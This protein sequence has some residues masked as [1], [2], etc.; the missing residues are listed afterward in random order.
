MGLVVLGEDHASLVAAVEPLADLVVQRL[1]LGDLAEQLGVAKQFAAQNYSI[2][3]LFLQVAIMPETWRVR[4]SKAVTPT[5]V[6]M[7]G[8]RSTASR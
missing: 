4:A 3:A 1:L 6:S 5:Q 7:S 2:R 8:P